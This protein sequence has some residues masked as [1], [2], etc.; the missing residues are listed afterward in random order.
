MS[1]DIET[2]LSLI[3]ISRFLEMVTKKDSNWYS[4]IILTEYRNF[5]ELISE[6]KNTDELIMV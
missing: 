5:V 4:F 3:L 2:K 1:K 6:K